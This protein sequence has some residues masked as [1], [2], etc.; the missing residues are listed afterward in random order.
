[1]QLLASLQVQKPPT[2]ENVAY[3][4][5]FDDG[6]IQD[7]DQAGGAGLNTREQLLQ[8]QEQQQ[9]LY[10]AR[11]EACSAEC[12]R[13]LQHLQCCW[14]EQDFVAGLR[15][16]VHAVRQQRQHLHQVEM[17]T[18]EEMKALPEQF[19]DQ[20]LYVKQQIALGA[21]EVEAAWPDQSGWPDRH[22]SHGQ[23]FEAWVLPQ[24]PDQDDWFWLNA[25]LRVE[26]PEG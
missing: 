3:K 9:L 6:T 17:M 21:V 16:V 12:K 15:P 7:V 4:L 2:Y 10:I 5:L 18:D 19:R 25:S 24:D 8:H 11:E 13:Q 1:L 20:V 14:F 23:H 26:F 22:L